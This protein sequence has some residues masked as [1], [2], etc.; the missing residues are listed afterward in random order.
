VTIVALTHDDDRAVV[1]VQTPRGG[2]D[3]EEELAEAAAEAE[4][5]AEE[6]E[7]GDEEESGED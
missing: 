2:T 1:S 5:Q 4:A 7:A 3:E 6:A